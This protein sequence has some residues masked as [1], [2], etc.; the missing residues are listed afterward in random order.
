MKLTQ[1]LRGMSKL[2]LVLLL[3]I[4][5]FLGAFLSYVWTM[6]FYAPSEFNLPSQANL[7]IENVQFYPEQPSFFNMTVLNPS[8]SAADAKIEQIN[9]HTSDGRSYAIDTTLPELSSLSIAPGKFE[10]IKSFWN[11]ANYTGQEVDVYVIL[12]KGSGPAVE[13][14]TAFMNFTLTNIV[15]EPSITSTRFNITVESKG[16]PVSVDIDRITVNGAEVNNTTP[17][18]PYKLDPNATATF[19]LYRNWADMQNTAVTVA[20]ETS[21]GYVALKAITAPE[22]KPVISNVVFFNMTT[23]FIFNI[24]IQNSAVPPIK[25]DIDSIGVYVEGQNITITDGSVNPALPKTLDPGSS[26]L[27]T[28]TWDWSPFAGKNTTITVYTAQGFKTSTETTIP[29]IP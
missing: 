9:V 19:T 26:L 29:N 8:Y 4:F 17:A 20:A 3:I 13:V 11:W 28:C 12:A 1:N 24:T 25:L 16:S 22:V 15:F 18:L 6:G 10:T 7:T 27:L 5:F 21:Q 23:S 2:I 14:R